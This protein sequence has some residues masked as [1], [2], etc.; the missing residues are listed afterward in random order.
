[1]KYGSALSDKH[2]VAL[3]PLYIDIRVMFQFL[4]NE[5][6]TIDTAACKM[7]LKKYLQD[8]L[9]LKKIG[10]I[11]EVEHVQPLSFEF[12]QELFKIVLNSAQFAQLTFAGK[13]GKEEMKV[14]GCSTCYNT[15]INVGDE[16]VRVSGETDLSVFY[17]G[18]CLFVWED[19]NLNQTLETPKEKGQ[20]LVEVKA[21]GEMYKV[22][23]GVEAPVIFGVETSGLNWRFCYRSYESGQHTMHL[24][25][26]ISAID[27][28]NVIIDEVV[29]ILTVSLIRCVSE[30]VSLMKLIDSR[31]TRPLRH[32]KPLEEDEE[33]DNYENDSDTNGST[34]ECDEV[35][36][37]CVSTLSLNPTQPS[38]SRNAAPKAGHNSGGS[39]GASKGGKSKSRGALLSLDNNVSLLTAENLYKMSNQYSQW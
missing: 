4:K 29:D 3:D 1:M 5:P 12:F 11:A 27:T 2:V 32:R 31:G 13:L 15:L 38:A 8:I 18:A 25:N 23:T 17:C 7:L 16:C 35:I 39:K 34:T 37:G 36:P 20:I 21:C 24:S 14:E 9:E 26:P 6:T 19:K 10:K 30:S 28:D 33:D 22:R